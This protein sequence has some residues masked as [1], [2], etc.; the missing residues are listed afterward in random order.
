MHLVIYVRREA[1]I[2]AGANRPATQPADVGDAVQNRP[3]Q[4]RSARYSWRATV[5]RDSIR[6]AVS[7]AAG[8]FGAAGA[9]ESDPASEAPGAKARGAVAAG[10]PAV[11]DS[12]PAGSPPLGNLGPRPGLLAVADLPIAAAR[13]IRASSPSLGDW[14]IGRSLAPASLTGLSVLVALVAAVWLSGG[15]PA[16]VVRGSAAGAVWLVTRDMAWR[17]AAFMAARKAG[18]ARTAR[19]FARPVV[20]A[21]SVPDGS[22][23]WLVLPGAS[24][25]GPKAPRRAAAALVAVTLSQGRRFA[26]A[27][28]TSTAASE[29]AIYA[30]IA[31]AGQAGRWT[32]MW[33]LAV[34][35]IVAVAVADLA[36]RCG[37]PPSATRP[38][39]RRGTAPSAL[40][41]RIA[42]VI[43]PTAA[44]RVVIALVALAVH[45]PRVSLF[46]V[47]AVVVITACADIIRLARR[48]AARQRQD[49][50]WHDAVLACR[51]D[52]PLARWAGRLVQGN[53]MPLPPL[54]IG[55]TATIGLAVL[56][57]R[58]L[59][60]IIVLAP[61]VVMLLAAPGSSHAHDGRLDR[62][63][64]ALLTLG[65]LIYLAAL[66]FAQAV[67]GPVVF[68]LCA[69]TGVWYAGLAS[70]ASPVPA[71]LGGGGRS[72]GRSGWP[73]GRSGWPA[74]RSGWPAGRSGR[75]AGRSGRSAGR[76]GSGRPAEQPGTGP[77]AGFLS[78]GAGW[79]GRMFLAGLTAIFGI[80]A[81]GYVCLAA[82]LGLLIGRKAMT[83]YLTPEE[84]DVR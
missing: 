31:A 5:A 7:R 56:G 45:G 37:D 52:G 4:P 27:F 77:V 1:A 84:N 68:A 60:G 72:A 18:S 47:L 2:L 73:A 69:M 22:T 21:A 54:L 82:Y 59:P 11:A 78:S 61:L 36:S 28:G 35:T 24:W 17:L 83:G 67:P 79:E 12:A 62:L 13:R 43:R 6:A 23:D 20:R 19:G 57:M 9:R 64:P 65:Q 8:G 46:A 38:A 39:R 42:R 29:F 76:S 33:P 74:G 71:I 50:P 16:D 32:S 70:G 41:A 15:T 80:A 30:G 53:L 63:A 34:I 81:F 48:S 75:S 25:P 66:G 26:W 10:D 3:V 55:L 44:A 40:L 49:L 58:N 14:A 51:D